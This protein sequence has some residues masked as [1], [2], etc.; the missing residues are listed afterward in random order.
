MTTE[1]M[2]SEKVAR[3][4]CQQHGTVTVRAGCYEEIKKKV[5]FIKTVDHGFIIYK[6]NIA[7]H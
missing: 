4:Q 6:I 2:A 3:K 1:S 7:W 5:I